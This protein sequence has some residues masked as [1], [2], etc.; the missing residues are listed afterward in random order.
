MR[1][2]YDNLFYWVFYGVRRANRFYGMSDLENCI[3]SFFILVMVTFVLDVEVFQIS[4]YYGITKYR[5]GIPDVLLIMIV[6]GFL[7][8]HKKHYKSVIENNANESLEKRKR[9]SLYCWILFASILL[10]IIITVIS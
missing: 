7:I 4:A 9:R 1:K 5:S 3:Y 2:M 10:P 6:H 8:F